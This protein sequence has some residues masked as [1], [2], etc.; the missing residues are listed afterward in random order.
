MNLHEIRMENVALTWEVWE[1]VSHTGNLNL[2]WWESHENFCF[3]W[4]INLECFILTWSWWE[5]SLSCVRVLWKISSPHEILW[6]H[7]RT[8][9]EKFS[10]PE[11][12]LGVP[13]PRRSLLLTRVCGS[14]L[15]SA[16]IF[17]ILL[18][19]SEERRSKRGST[20]FNVVRS[21]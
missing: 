19:S 3:I 18:I 6:D 20:L 1:N 15:N 14:P 9:G 5:C 21:L 16:K 11:K 17:F 7:M 10:T 13:V 2:T 12:L 8:I 4:W